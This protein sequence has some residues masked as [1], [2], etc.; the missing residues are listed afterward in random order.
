MISFDAQNEFM[1]E[2]PLEW[3]SWLEVVVVQE[4]FTLGELCF[5]FCS[6][7]Y[8]VDLNQK[9]L[10]HDTLTDII[11]FDYNVGKT[12]NGE[13]YISTERV[14]ENCVQYKAPMTHELARVVVHGVLHLCGY[15]DKSEEELALMRQREDYWIS[16]FKIL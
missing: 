11:T 15:K 4:G 13:V 2:R 8:L 10:S 6:D 14:A 5:V 12:I 7:E 9:F 16:K 1:I 3:V